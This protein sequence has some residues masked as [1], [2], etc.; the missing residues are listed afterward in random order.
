MEEDKE[1]QWLREQV[2]LLQSEIKKV[3]AGRD[4]WFKAKCDADARAEKAEYD[5]DEWKKAHDDLLNRR[6]KTMD[7]AFS[8]PPPVGSYL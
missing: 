1:I 5:R 7:R 2:K 6:S 3:E 8:G 4:N